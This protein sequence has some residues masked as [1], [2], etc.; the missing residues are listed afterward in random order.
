VA[1]LREPPLPEAGPIEPTPTVHL[2]HAALVY[3]A[4][5]ASGQGFFEPALLF[6]GTFSVASQAYEKRV[7]VPALD[8]A[9]LLPGHT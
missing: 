1:A 5:P 4:V 3:V 9:L 6:T 8:S 7:L 2:T